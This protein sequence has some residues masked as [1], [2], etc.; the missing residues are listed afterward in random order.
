MKNNNQ[1]TI[2]LLVNN[3]PGVLI[4]IALVF[5]RRGYNIDSL[6][7]SPANDSSFSRMTITATG[8]VKTLEQII[9]QLNKVVD[10]IHATDHT[11]D[12]VVERELVLIKLSIQPEQRSEVLQVTDH[13]KCQ[14]VDISKDTLT[15]ESTGS[16]E[17]ID[18]LVTM[19]QDYSIMEV[20]RTGKVLMS[21][22]LTAT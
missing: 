8:E 13:F 16:T 6:V 21:R 9:K 15:I 3:K 7:V 4:R 17:K 22:G 5:A 12:V 19:M 18:A 1:H 20:V 14:S 11:D 10:V 2:S